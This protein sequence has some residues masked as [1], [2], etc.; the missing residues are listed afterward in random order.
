MTTWLKWLLAILAIIVFQ[1]GTMLVAGTLA[2]A[3]AKQQA[4]AAAIE[5]AATT[6]NN[7]LDACYRGTKLR[8]AINYRIEA[9]RVQNVV[10]KDFI[11][12]SAKFRRASGELALARQS[13]ALAARLQAIRF[14]PVNNPNCLTTIKRPRGVPDAVVPTLKELV[15]RND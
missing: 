11:D 8:V 15:D 1:S 3:K 4:E 12:S 13:E 9:N 7:Q 6:Y 5:R 2:T 14:R 10:L